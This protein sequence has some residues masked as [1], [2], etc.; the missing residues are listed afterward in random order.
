MVVINSF[1]ELEINFFDGIPFDEDGGMLYPFGK[2]DEQILNYTEQ[3]LVE[4]NLCDGYV[5]ISRNCKLA[6][7]LDQLAHMYECES[8]FHWDKVFIPDPSRTFFATPQVL[9]KSISIYFTG[10][11]ISATGKKLLIK[12]V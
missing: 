1:D 5:A 11:Y 2:T 9:A 8:I 7:L 10:I 6:R 3:T 4:T 12:I